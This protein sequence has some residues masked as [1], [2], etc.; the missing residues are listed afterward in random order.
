MVACAASHP[1]SMPPCARLDARTEAYLRKMRWSSIPSSAAAAA[2]RHD[3]RTRMRNQP[4]QGLRVRA[5]KIRAVFVERKSVRQ[6]ETNFIVQGKRVRHDLVGLSSG[7]R[8][9][10]AANSSCRNSRH[11]LRGIGR[12]CERSRRSAA[13]RLIASRFRSAGGRSCAGAVN[14]AAGQF[15]AFRPWAFA[16]PS[17]QGDREPR[18]HGRSRRSL[19]SSRQWN[20][21]ARNWVPHQG[22]KPL[23]RGR[24]RR[25]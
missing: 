15:G 9:Q 18:R 4:R 14:C 8:W 6:A 20:A 2:A 11:N 25:C 19:P 10:S 17:G 3:R 5:G 23:S 1:I 7:M 21:E 16:S 12:A 22:R 24:A 13:R